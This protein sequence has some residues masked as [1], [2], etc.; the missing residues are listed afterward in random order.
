MLHA[1]IQ[2]QHSMCRRQRMPAMDEESTDL[3]GLVAYLSCLQQSQVRILEGVHVVNDWMLAGMIP[4]KHHGFMFR[5]SE[6]R[7]LTLD[8]GREGIT[9]AVC[10]VPP[11]V[12]DGTCLVKRYRINV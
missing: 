2:P 10:T 3:K 8:F 6:N 9:W 5:T 12:P 4:L 7:F 11:E 1:K